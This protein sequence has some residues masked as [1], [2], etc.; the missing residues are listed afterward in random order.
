MRSKFNSIALKLLKGISQQ[1]TFAFGVNGRS[2]HAS[3]IPSR[4]N[5]NTLVGSIYVHVGGHA[6]GLAVDLHREG[7]HAALLVQT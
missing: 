3:P 4:A 1:Q 6:H 5:L 2:L 7:Q